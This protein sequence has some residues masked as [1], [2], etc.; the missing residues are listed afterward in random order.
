MSEPTIPPVATYAQPAASPR[1]S[2]YNSSAPHQSSASAPSAHMYVA[3]TAATTAAAPVSAFSTYQ[4]NNRSSSAHSGGA[5]YPEPSP[6]ST[7]SGSP[8]PQYQHQ[9]HAPS[10]VAPPAYYQQHDRSS[11]QAGSWTGGEP[12]DRRSTTTPVSTYHGATPVTP[13]SA[14][15]PMPGEQGTGGGS[16]GMP[17]VPLILQPGMGY[18]P[19]RPPSSATTGPGRPATAGSGTG[20][21]RER[22]DSVGEFPAAVGVAKAVSISRKPVARSTSGLKPQ[23]AVPGQSQSSGAVA[24]AANNGQGAEQGSAAELP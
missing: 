19:Y 14:L 18:R 2:A 3:P 12:L 21:T 7:P 22:N 20:N 5:Y 4:N 1:G 16:G 15:G 11:N 9:P 13:A 10:P 23:Q 6:L 17:G 24:P 8:R